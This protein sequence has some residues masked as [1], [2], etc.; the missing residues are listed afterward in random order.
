M[1]LAE[2]ADI[3]GIGTDLTVVLVVAG[4]ALGIA[5][6]NMVRIKRIEDR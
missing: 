2:V 6:R 5:I 1:E 3:L 4:V